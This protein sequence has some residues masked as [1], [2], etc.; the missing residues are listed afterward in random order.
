[1]PGTRGRE[2]GEALRMPLVCPFQ[3][4]FPCP[5]ESRG[6]AP[7]AYR[8]IVPVFSFFGFSTSHLWCPGVEVYVAGK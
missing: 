5:E 1:M 6:S 2:A 3:D 8:A 7:E 4:R